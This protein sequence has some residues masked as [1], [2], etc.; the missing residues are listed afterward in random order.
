M[1]SWE[2]DIAPVRETLSNLSFDLI[3]AHKI[4]RK[5]S[6]CLGLERFATN[7]FTDGQALTEVK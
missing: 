2:A 1:V 4:T 5:D 3:K 6:P 7:F